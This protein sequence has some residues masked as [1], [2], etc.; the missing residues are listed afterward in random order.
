MSHCFIYSTTFTSIPVGCHDFR[1]VVQCRDGSPIRPGAV[2]ELYDHDILGS[3][4]LETSRLK[5]IGD[6]KTATFRWNGCYN[7]GGVLGPE[8]PEILK[9]PNIEAFYTFHNVCREGDSYK[10]KDVLKDTDVYVLDGK[11]AELM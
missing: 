1:G 3:D 5:I 7:D 6:G 10:A 2:I 9:Y 8:G 11:I 4:L